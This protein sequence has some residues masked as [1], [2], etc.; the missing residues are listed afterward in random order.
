[1]TKISMDKQYTSNGKPVRLLCIDGPGDYPVVGFRY[2]QTRLYTWTLDGRYYSRAEGSSE[3]LIEAK[4]DVVVWV[5]EYTS[6]AAHLWWST[7]QEAD[8]IC[9]SDRIAVHE[10]NLT[11]GTITRH[12]VEK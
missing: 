12:E 1:M 11:K 6:G 5:N 7:R 3:D 2:G 9:E 4:L 8:E 10:I